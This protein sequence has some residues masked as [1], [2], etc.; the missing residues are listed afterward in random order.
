MKNMKAAYNMYVGTRMRTPKPCYNLEGRTGSSM[1]KKASS[2]SGIAS[3]AAGP[4]VSVG[5]DVSGGCSEG[6]RALCSASDGCHRRRAPRIV[7]APGC[8]QLGL[9]VLGVGALPPRFRVRLR[10]AGSWSSSVSELIKSE[11]L[12]ET[13]TFFINPCHIKKFLLFYSIK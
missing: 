11:V 8:V 1:Q 5:V 10:Q 4:V 6:I 9:L 7:P 13:Q 3:A 12:F 2:T